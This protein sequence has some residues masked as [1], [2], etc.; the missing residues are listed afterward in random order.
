MEEMS[1][2]PKGFCQCGCGQKTP[3]V[4]ISSKKIREASWELWDWLTGNIVD[5]FP[6]ED[7]D[8]I[9]RKIIK[10]VRQDKGDPRLEL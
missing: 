4:D 1:E 2:I 10:V 3:T 7:C 8:E 5:E 9:V 6:V